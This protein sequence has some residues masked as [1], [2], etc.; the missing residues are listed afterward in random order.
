MR[1]PL[2]ISTIRTE[3]DYR[4]V[5]ASSADLVVKFGGDRPPRDVV[6]IIGTVMIVRHCGEH[7]HVRAHGA[8]PRAA[9]WTVTAHRGRGS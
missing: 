1:W 6:I 3:S 4:Y 8:E 2:W 7:A 9:C 5:A